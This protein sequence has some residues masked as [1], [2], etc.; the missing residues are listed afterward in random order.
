MWTLDN[1]YRKVDKGNNICR[2]IYMG[3]SH[4]L[5]IQLIQCDVAVLLS[6]PGKIFLSVVLISVNK[7]PPKVN[8][9]VTNNSLWQRGD[10]QRDHKLITGPEF[11]SAD[12]QGCRNDVKGLSHGSGSAEY[13]LKVMLR[14]V[15]GCNSCCSLPL[16]PIMG[17]Q[18][19]SV[20]YSSHPKEG[21][22]ATGV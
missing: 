18:I 10:T 21:K 19:K 22:A 3:R 11:S 7:W 1:G 13:V 14:T 15:T 4:T 20:R 9:A 2:M 6:K 17:K 5:I 8:K 12:L 16:V